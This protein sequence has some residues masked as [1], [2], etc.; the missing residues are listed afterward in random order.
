M[1][2]CPATSASVPRTGLNRHASRA[3][4]SLDFPAAVAVSGLPPTGR[5]AAAVSWEDGAIDRDRDAASH[6]ATAESSLAR[7]AGAGPARPA[8]PAAAAA[9][10]GG[11]AGAMP[12]A[13][14]RGEPAAVPA[15]ERR[16][17]GHPAGDV[18]APPHA[19]PHHA[20]VPHVPRRGAGLRRRQHRARGRRQLQHDAGGAA[21][22]RRGRGRRRL[23]IEV[24]A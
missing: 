11:Q 17:D 21:H 23:R 9:L 1:L 8:R 3:F 24:T 7:R 6:A 14:Q 13:R 18:A 20:R 15:G 10:L 12:P 5:G 22:R 4:G 19:P 16:A 2:R